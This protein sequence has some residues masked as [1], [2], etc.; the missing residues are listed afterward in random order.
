MT[1]DDQAMLKACRLIHLL[2]M[3]SYWNNKALLVALVE[4]WH[5]ENNTFNLLIE[6]IIVTPE[7]VYL[8]LWILIT[9]ELVVYDV[10]E[11]GGADAL[12]DIFG[13]PLIVGYS[14]GWQEMVDGYAPLPS[15]I[16][17]LVDD[18]LLPYRRSHGLSVGWGCV[19]RQ[20]VRERTHY[21]CRICVL[22]HLY[23]GLHQIVYGKD[24][25]PV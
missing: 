7:D 22:A 14:V 8:I 13:D 11:I 19:L 24:Q 17:G 4:I 10:E 16:V 25:G 15:V 12:Q 20:M 2:L 5:S 21:A 6:E 9:G 1:D 18:S 3:P 23:H